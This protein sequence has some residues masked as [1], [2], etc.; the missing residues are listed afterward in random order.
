MP[1]EL[2]PRTRGDLIPLPYARETEAVVRQVHPVRF[3][4]RNRH[5][6][7]PLAAP[8]AMWTAG[9]LV[10][11]WHHGFD[12]DV[13]SV[14]ADAVMW[15]RAPGKWSAEPRV[16]GWRWTSEAA[17]ARGTVIGAGTWLCW[18]AASGVHG[19]QEVF[20]LIGSAVWGIPFWLHKRPR[21]KR[22]RRRHARRVTRWNAWW[23]SHAPAWGL[24][25]SGVV[26][27]TDHGPVMETL[28]VQL[29]AGRQSIASVRNISHLLESALNGYV[30]ASMSRIEQVKSRPSQVLVHLKKED[31]LS[32]VIEWDE[33]LVSDDIMDP[34][35]LGVRETG[36]W[37]EAGLRANWFV[38]GVTRSGKSN[39]LNVKLAKIT[40]CRN[41]RA[42]VID[43]KGG[44][45]ARPWLPAIDWL[46][47]TTGEADMLLLFCIAEIKARAA[48]ADNGE[49]E[50]LT[51]TAEVPTLFL[52]IDETYEVTSAMSGA[53]GAAR[54]AGWLATVA[55]QGSGV[56]VY[57]I[58][59]TQH[60]TLG[61]SVGTEETR[62][63]L[64]RRMCFQTEH[65]DHG[66]F[67]LG[68]DAQRSVDTTTLQQKGAFYYRQDSQT[69]P[70]QV[71]G[72]HIPRKTARQIAERNAGR[73]GL[74]ARPL[75]A[76]CGAQPVSAGEG[77]LT[78]QQVYDQRWSRLP[79]RLLDDGPQ[80]AVAGGHSPAGD[81]A[82][83]SKIS[84]R[85]PH[86]DA[87]RINAEIDEQPDVSDED[88]LRGRAL[89]AA[90][91][92]PPVDLRSKTDRGIDR[93]ASLLQSA[94]AEG[95][96]PK[97]LQIGSGMSESWMHPYLGKLT[98][99]GAVAKVGHGRYVVT[100]GADIREALAGIRR[101][102]AA[103]AAEARDL[104][105]R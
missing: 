52:V 43:M 33:S 16:R 82:P 55:S 17:Y 100:G 6:T 19:G 31:P 7:I 62:A 11:A 59:V 47:T 24:P 2:E 60:G 45:A 57:V 41:A 35:G 54:R 46:A 68:D 95:I 99:T 94:P 3:A 5:A 63:N 102:A 22:K 101:E 30:H 92:E 37:L 10:R 26:D 90:R 85:P 14:A 86:P 40:K 91:G 84:I 103:R 50:Q 81:G 18:A 76:Y 53:P 56:E 77:A 42:L 88:I 72:P 15:V 27:V 44:R 96:S 49:D 61:E 64:R 8:V 65:R 36:G 13:I 25:G 73:T 58:V 80:L 83:S 20:L 1:A 78:W 67:T 74:H 51:P 97:Q 70:E 66:I 89:R 79:A 105:K 32:E 87:E 69:R 39:N 9:H 34:V 23:Q 71:R 75:V 21:D 29:W 48:Y 4:W 93:F 12:L 104:V 38:N 28:T 98:E